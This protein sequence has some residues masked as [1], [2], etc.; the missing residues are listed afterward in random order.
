M[1][2][3]NLAGRLAAMTAT[4]V[5][6]STLSAQWN[7]PANSGA[8]LTA[9]NP[10]AIGTT[11]SQAAQLTV[12]TN[13]ANN[14]LVLDALHANE[15]AYIAF[16]QY[17]N[18]LWVFGAGTYGGHAFGLIDIL[19]PSAARWLVDSSGRFGI[20][21]NVPLYTLDV[22][23]TGHVSGDLTV[24]GNIAAPYQDVAEWVP[25][26]ESLTAGTV[27]IIDPSRTNHVVASAH[28]YDTHVA[29]VISARPGIALGRA[30][31][32]KYQV[33][34]MGRVRVK[35]DATTNPIAVGDLL[36]TSG[37]T[38]M[39]MRSMPATLSGI[40]IHRPGTILGKALEPLASG[41]GEILI[42]LSLQ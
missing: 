20:N 19:S 29:G 18:P 11:T 33:A 27:V 26:E 28:T 8:T 14:A 40:E 23:G 16:Y 15:T 13:G 36:V 3:I 22:N 10:T 17:N 5:W 7:T 38:G 39:A 6:G 32:G 42:L 4:I 37:T 34:T 2:A 12:A 25:G 35:V 31:A 21:T 41:Q 9:P 30:G 1:R 24:D